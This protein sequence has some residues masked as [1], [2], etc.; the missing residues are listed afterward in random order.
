MKSFSIPYKSELIVIVMVVVFFVVIKNRFQYVQAA[1][2]AVEAGKQTIEERKN[3]AGR[4]SS[5]DKDFTESMQGFLLK[6]P[7][8]FKSIIQDKA[9]ANN[10]N[11]INMRSGQDMSG[12]L[13]MGS[14]DL[15]ISGDYKDT[16]KFI[17]ALEEN[18]LRIMNLSVAG[19]E[20]KKDI[21]MKVYCYFSKD[22]ENG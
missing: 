16:V 8:D 1:V 15:A 4:W 19:T 18:N 17:K 5:V 7:V 21:S 14:L 6:D 11:L 20:K 12:V 3:L 13:G 22:N 2:A 9:W 10:I